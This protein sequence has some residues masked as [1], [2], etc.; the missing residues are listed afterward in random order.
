ME[1]RRC[2]L[3]GARG[4]QPELLPPGAHPWAPASGWTGTRSTV[5]IFLFFCLFVCLLSQAGF[6]GN[7]RL[8]VFTGKGFDYGAPLLC[9]RGVISTD[10]AFAPL[11]EA[12]GRRPASRVP[13][14]CPWALA[15]C[16]F[17]SVVFSLFGKTQQIIPAN[18]SGA[19]LC[20]SREPALGPCSQGRR[21]VHARVVHKQLRDQTG[22]RLCLKLISIPFSRCLYLLFGALNKAL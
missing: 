1:V 20:V 6:S 12:L 3:V 11:G 19:Q 2:P 14:A 22:G 4:V 18:S 10:T 5:V 7:R 17:C 21:S 15:T 9:S 13:L 8:C 16:S